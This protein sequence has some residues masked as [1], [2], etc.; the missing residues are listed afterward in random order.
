VYTDIWADLGRRVDD[1]A[2]LVQPL[3]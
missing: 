3:P 2:P 1:N